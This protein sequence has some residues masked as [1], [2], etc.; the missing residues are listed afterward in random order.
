MLASFSFKIFA[1]KLC[2]DKRLFNH[3]LFFQVLGLV[4]DM[5]NHPASTFLSEDFPMTVNSDDPAIW[6][7]TGLSYD[8]YELFMGMTRMDDDLR[9]LKQLAINSIKYGSL[10]FSIFLHTYILD[11]VYNGNGNSIHKL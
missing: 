4:A 10:L 9:L 11:Y 5:R 3:F 7:A 2:I 1:S 6:G 8:F